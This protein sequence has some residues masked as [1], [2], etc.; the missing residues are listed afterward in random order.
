M[1]LHVCVNFDMRTLLVLKFGGKAWK[2]KVFDLR[3]A[4]SR[5]RTVL[6]APWLKLLNLLM[7]Q[8]SSDLC[9]GSRFNERIEY[10]LFSFC[11]LSFWFTSSCVYHLITV[12]TFVLTIYH[13]LPRPFIPDLKL[14]ISVTNPFL[15]SIV[16]SGHWR[17]SPR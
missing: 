12:T 7:S 2:G 9:T 16:F 8:P 10:K 15:Q 1:K 6:H 5:Y 3:I 13:S 11:S 14:V 17:L 4:S